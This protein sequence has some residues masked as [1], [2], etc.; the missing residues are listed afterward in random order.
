MNRRVNVN[1]KINRQFQIK[2]VK[3]TYLIYNT[4][5][6]SW[7]GTPSSYELPLCFR[8]TVLKKDSMICLVGYIHEGF[9]P[10]LE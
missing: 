8:V 6:N 9:H 7:G 10:V 5:Y 1:V 2:Y 4:Q 3:F